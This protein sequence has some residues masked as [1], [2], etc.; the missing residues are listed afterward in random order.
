MLLRRFSEHVKGQNWFAVALDFLIV[1]FGVFIGFQL[2]TWNDNRKLDEAYAQA[3]ARLV[4]ESEANITAIEA[5]IRQNE[6]TLPVV[7]GAIAAFESCDPG[8]ESEA[9]F[10]KGLNQI[11]GTQSLKLR[12]SA[13]TALTHNEGLLSRQTEDERDRLGEFERALMRTQEN[14]DFLEHLPFDSPVEDH[15]AI[16]LAALK[17]ARLSERSWDVISYRP[18]TLAVPFAQA[19]REPALAKKFYEW[20]RIASFQMLRARQFQ[21][22]LETNLDALGAQPPG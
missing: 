21:A 17:E 22:T 8:E 16:T 14:L 19:C 4:A 20:E 5:L 2:N 18:L 6:T 11:R 13:L 7:R 15:P 1:V 3:R 9:A 12:D 10:L